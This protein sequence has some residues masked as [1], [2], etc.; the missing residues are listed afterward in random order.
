[1]QWLDRWCKVNTWH[2][3]HRAL[4]SLL[5]R[6]IYRDPHSGGKK[7]RLEKNEVTFSRFKFLGPGSILY[8]VLKLVL[9]CGPSWNKNGIV[10]WGFK[11]VIFSQFLLLHSWLVPW[12]PNGQGLLSLEWPL[13]IQYLYRSQ[14][15]KNLVLLL[16]F[17]PNETFLSYMTS[18]GW[19]EDKG[20]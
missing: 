16:H 4:W 14:G 20:G 18:K 3:S 10:C 1:M 17:L 11:S 13:P 12:L 9:G 15:E 5:R 8:K 19:L 2:S 6:V 7:T